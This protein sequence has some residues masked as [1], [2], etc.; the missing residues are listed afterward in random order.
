MTTVKY[1]YIY[2][3]YPSLANI[4]S[5]WLCVNGTHTPLF[6]KPKDS[7]ILPS[8]DN[9]QGDKDRHSVWQGLQGIPEG[10]NAAKHQ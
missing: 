10:L 9:W 4:V 5:L 7:K 1:I 8:L 3:F 6:F 2:R